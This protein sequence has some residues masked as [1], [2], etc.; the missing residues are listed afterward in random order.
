MGEWGG[1]GDGAQWG[2]TVADSADA[3]VGWHQGLV[4]RTGT[5]AFR[6]SQEVCEPATEA[7]SVTFIRTELFLIDNPLISKHISPFAKLYGYRLSVLPSS[8]RCAPYS[9]DGVCVSDSSSVA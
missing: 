9:V 5:L 8:P 2:W 4:A 7:W 1:Q 6:P 3:P